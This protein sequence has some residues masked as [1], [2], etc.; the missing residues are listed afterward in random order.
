MRRVIFHAHT[1]LDG[2]I[3]NREGMFWQP[4]PWGEEEMNYIND[5][6]RSADTWVLGRLMHDV[7]VPWWTD[8]AA[9]KIPEGVAQ[10]GPASEEFARIFLEL[11]IVV[12]SRALAGVG[13]MTVLRADPVEELMALKKAGGRDIILSC[14][15]DLLAPLATAPDLI[16]EYAF[17]MHPMVLSTGKRLFEAMPEDLPLRLVGSRVFQGG[18]VVVRYEPLRL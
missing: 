3:A 6:F 2:R 1:T 13:D 5:L 9:G 15:P 12:F 17:A 18:A 10:I 8:V 11:D 4:F 14:G 7:I 16:D